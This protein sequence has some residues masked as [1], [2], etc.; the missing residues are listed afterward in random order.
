M[1]RTAETNLIFYYWRTWFLFGLMATVSCLHS[2]KLFF[3]ST[4][5]TFLDVAW[6]M[7]SALVVAGCIFFFGLRSA[8]IH[9]NLYAFLPIYQILSLRLLIEAKSLAHRFWEFVCSSLLIAALI[10]SLLNPA[11]ALLLFPYYLTSGSTYDE[12]KG[13]FEEILPS[14]CAVVYTASIAFL[15]ESQSGSNYIRSK[16]SGIIPSE[17]MKS[18]GKT[19]TCVIAF[20]QEVNSNDQNKPPISMKLVADM[21]DRSR[22]T[23]VLRSLRVLNS[24]KGYSFKAYRHDNPID[25]N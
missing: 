6:F 16:F 15:D 11:H 22:Y 5:F 21:S 25:L 19:K 3:R 17:R 1:G 12:M 9:Y 8:P 4:A 13:K 18:E 10:L 23:D 20:V 7:F 2:A 14:K 24:P